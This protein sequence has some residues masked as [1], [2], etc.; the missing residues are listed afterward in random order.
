MRRPPQAASLA[1][2]G[3]LWSW[4]RRNRL[5]GEHPIPEELK[6]G[7]DQR[8]RNPSRQRHRARWRPLGGGQDQHRQARQGRRLQPGRTE[9]PDQRHQAQRALPLGRD[10]RADPARA[11]GFFLPLRAGRRAGVHGHRELRAARTA[12]GFR[13]RS[14]RLPAGRHDGDG[15]ALRGEADRHLAAR[16]GDADHHRGRPGGEGPDGGLVLQAGDAGERHPRAGA[17]LHR[18]RASASSSTPTK[19]P[20]CAAPTERAAGR[21]PTARTRWRAP[22]SS[23][24]WS[25]PP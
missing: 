23:T 4:R 13:R 5:S 20:T 9:E 22:H 14:R 2:S 3:V 21:K 24:S 8:Q 1:S 25:R 18:R 11:E 19:S 17:A 7:Q 16:P 6:H 12:E 15:P 10:G